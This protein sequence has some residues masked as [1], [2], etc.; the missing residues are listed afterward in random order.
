MSKTYF[1]G[2]GIKTCVLIIIEHCVIKIGIVSLYMVRY[3]HVSLYS[4]FTKIKLKW[5]YEVFE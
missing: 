3:L 2:N 4:Y 1:S 5:S